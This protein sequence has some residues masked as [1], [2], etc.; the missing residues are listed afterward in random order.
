MEWHPDVP[1]L[2]IKKPKKIERL[3]KMD[4][5]S[6]DSMPKVEVQEL[7]DDAA[8]SVADA[9]KK[10]VKGANFDECVEIV[11]VA[12][13]VT[14]SSIG[15]TVGTLMVAESESASQRACRLTFPLPEER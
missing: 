14:G 5:R 9:Y 6:L 15:G 11:S 3:E 4:R 10:E 7:V 2:P 1:D 12:L 8:Q 13:S